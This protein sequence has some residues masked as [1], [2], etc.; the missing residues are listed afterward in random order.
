MN[1][2]RAPN[3]CFC[4]VEPGATLI[5]SLIVRKASG[6]VALA[7]EQGFAL[8]MDASIGLFFGRGIVRR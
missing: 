4:I 5:R 8:Y 2:T 1:V 7:A 3:A 6:D